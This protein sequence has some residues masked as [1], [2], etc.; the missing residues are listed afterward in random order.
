[1]NMSDKT[2]AHEQFSLFRTSLSEKLEGKD[3]IEAKR[4]AK[5]CFSYAAL[6]GM[7]PTD[8]RMKK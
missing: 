5:G 3:I 8:A 1:M 2:F 4:A 6:L 7:N